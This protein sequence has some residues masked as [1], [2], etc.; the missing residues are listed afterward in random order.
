MLFCLIGVAEAAS[1]DLLAE[2]LVGEYFTGFMPLRWLEIGGL[3][4]LLT[5]LQ[6]QKWVHQQRPRRRDHAVLTGETG[7]L[8][9]RMPVSHQQSLSY[10]P[11]AVSLS[12]SCDCCTE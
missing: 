12:M 2:P 9:T 3:M 8:D 10:Y 1:T 4:L 11:S 5:S 6:Q 7:M